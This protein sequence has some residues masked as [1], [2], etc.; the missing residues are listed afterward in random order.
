V[1]LLGPRFGT[2]AS[3]GTNTIASQEVTVLRDAGNAPATT[4]EMSES[5]CIRAP[6]MP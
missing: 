1:R 5:V 3:E 6:A 4:R 2:I